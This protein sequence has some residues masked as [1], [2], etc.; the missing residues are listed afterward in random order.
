MNSQPD[1][2]LIQGDWVLVGYKTLNENE[3]K[4]Y[5]DFY[6]M[7]ILTI[8]SDNILC[9]YSFFED[10]PISFFH[11][12]YNLNERALNIIREREAWE[13]ED[14][15][16]NVTLKVV[17]VDEY[18]L[19]LLYTMYNATNQI[20][21]QMMELHY[22]AIIN[23]P[24][25]SELPSL[26]EKLSSNTWGT[27]EFSLE[28]FVVNGAN[29]KYRCQ[30]KEGD[31]IVGLWHLHDA[32]GKKLLILKENCGEKYLYQIQKVS[33]DEIHLIQLNPNKRIILRPCP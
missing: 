4:G 15:T 10:T 7:D 1:N 29:K 25:I 30:K 13:Q 5:W 9:T 20:Y 26:A 6:G 17:K 32:S 14:N 21:G 3:L 18:E 11:Y 19:T 24:I 2:E 23:S 27:N 12:A 28:F 22:A 31:T 33:H 16:F 8:S